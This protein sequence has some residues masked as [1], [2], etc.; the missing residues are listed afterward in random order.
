MCWVR[1]C[2]WSI[3]SYYQGRAQDI[4]GSGTAK[5]GWGNPTTHTCSSHSKVDTSQQGPSQYSLRVN[6]YR[7]IRLTWEQCL[8]GLFNNRDDMNRLPTLK[9]YNRCFNGAGTSSRHCVFGMNLLLKCSQ[10]VNGINK[11]YTF[12]NIHMFVNFHH[13]RTC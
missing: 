5:G 10:C 4:W 13:L 9:C 1:S 2:G 8:T 12:T 7:F 3:W 11:H 6:G